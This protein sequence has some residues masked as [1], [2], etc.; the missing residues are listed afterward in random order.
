[1]T[2]LLSILFIERESEYSLY[3]LSLE[4][5]KENRQSVSPCSKKTKILSIERENKDSLHS[6]YREKRN[7]QSLHS[8][9]KESKDFRYSLYT[10]KQDNRL[11]VS[12][13]VCP[14]L[15]CHYPGGL[16]ARR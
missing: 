7:V 3:A 11:S 12:P 16:I 1:M 13:C 4:G 6:R 14:A 5:T 15:A 8:H 9:Y 10:E 2:K